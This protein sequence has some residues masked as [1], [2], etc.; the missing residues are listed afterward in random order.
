MN[1]RVFGDYKDTVNE[2]EEEESCQQP[3]PD[4]LFVTQEGRNV[5]TKLDFS[6]AYQQLELLNC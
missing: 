2:S 3:I 6:S 1:F 5:F 4:D